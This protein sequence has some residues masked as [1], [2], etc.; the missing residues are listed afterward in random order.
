VSAARVVAVAL[1]AAAAGGAALLTGAFDAPV[2]P[3][4]H[5]TEGGDA[6]AAETGS[7]SATKDPPPPGLARVVDDPEMRERWRLVRAQDGW[8]R[9]LRLAEEKKLA[10]ALAE[11]AAIREAFPAF[12]E[13]KERAA[14]AARIEGELRAGAAAKALA[15][16]VQ[17]LPL[18][19][20]QRA[21]LDRRL[22]A[23]AE[24]LSGAANEADLDQL[25][26]H[27][28]RFLVPD[29]SAMTGGAD[30]DWVRGPLST[31]LTDRRA[32]RATD[33]NPAI[34]D[35]EAAE[36]RRI[37]ELDKLR[38]RDAVGLLDH[39]HAALA[40]LAIHQRDDG[41][42]G[43]AGV[44]ERC[45]TLKHEPN[46]LGNY[47]N[48]GDNYQVATTGLACIAFLDFRDQDVN[49]WFDPYLGRGLQWLVKQQ[50]PDGGFKGASTTYTSAIAL[51]AL[52]Q[53]AASTGQAEYRD[54]VQKGLTFFQSA[55]G[56]LGNWRYGPRPDPRG[57]TSVTA[58]VAQA[59]EASR[60]A[61][62]E[63][64]PVLASS[65]ENYLRYFWLGDSRFL[66]VYGEPAPR[67]S[68]SPAGMLIGHVGGKT[69]DAAVS[70]SWLAYLRSR[71]VQP[72]PDLYTLYY[73]VRIS[74]L[75]ANALDGPWRTW[76]FEIAD[77]QIKTGNAAGMFPGDLWR[78]GAGPTVQTA[79]AVLTLEHAL[80]LR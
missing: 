2:P 6:A 77:K 27:L 55:L 78:W 19:A 76:V 10:E 72:R 48:V 67:E 14:K 26:R 71:P 75:L 31:F 69:K 80:Y 5:E 49:G 24:V 15:V 60:L 70:A 46:C 12:L 22:A 74:I 33:S 73:G 61:G 34:A 17:T 16:S 4:A 42:F 65:F 28:R 3:V 58:W 36:K 64:P 32:R 63:T 20:E 25:S 23:T 50:R 45:K 35:A 59:I 8:A 62:I 79:I 30:K 44:V 18:T 1:V 9:A 57:D 7:G 11:I 47:P 68:L 56:P 21:L 38:Q 66:Y 29:G 51:M 37:E 41:S 39:I 40:W 43:D 13:D 53:A 54:A 52:G